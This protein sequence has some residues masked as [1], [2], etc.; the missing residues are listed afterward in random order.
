MGA[1]LQV[2]GV[3]SGRKRHW[4]GG[5]KRVREEARPGT[6]QGG[7]EEVVI[8]GWRPGGDFRGGAVSGDD[9]TRAWLWQHRGGGVTA[10]C[11]NFIK[12]GEASGCQGSVTHNSV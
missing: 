2:I 4:A 9:R 12:T 11:Q 7:W 8:R 5:L 6:A 3:R 1:G 10:T